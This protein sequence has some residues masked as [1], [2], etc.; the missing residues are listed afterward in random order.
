M[1]VFGNRLFGKVDQVPGL[2]HVA[3]KFFHVNFVPLFPLGSWVVLH[4]SEKSSLTGT[5][6]NGVELERIRWSSVSM[7]W[8]RL[9]LGIA[10]GIFAGATLAQVAGGVHPRAIAAALFSAS[11]IAG[12]VLSYRLGRAT[13]DSLQRLAADANVPADLVHA[14]RAAMARH[15]SGLVR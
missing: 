6:W 3:T 10:A 13:E 4:G 14:A 8:L 11:C 2:F 9:G 5:S 15:R 12:L 1:F 7:A